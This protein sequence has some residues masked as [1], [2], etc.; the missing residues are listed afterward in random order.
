[1]DADDNESLAKNAISIAAREGLVIL[2]QHEVRFSHDSF[3]EAAYSLLRA[4]DR[5]SF[6]LMLG[7][8]LVKHIP[9]NLFQ[10]HLF[11]VAV[12]LALGLSSITNN[13]DDSRITFIRVFLDAGDESN[14]ASAFP[15][16][17]SWFSLG[18][19]LLREQDWQENYLLS[20]DIYLKARDASSTAQE[21]NN[22]NTCL[23]VIFDRCKDDLLT[24]L[25]GYFI[26]IRTL[27]VN[28]DPRS[29]DVILEALR[30]VGI[31]FPSKNMMLHVLVSRQK[32]QEHDLT[33]MAI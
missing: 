32:T 20:A 14:S 25:T 3:T 31:Q 12:Q 18:I 7:E 16:A 2:S 17:M 4:E 15:V 13:H 24:V 11:T 23:A 9:K 10:K 22:M 21:Y 26:R 8:I 33:Y 5:C 27:A 28:E 6:H 1:M 30:L 29:I 19:S